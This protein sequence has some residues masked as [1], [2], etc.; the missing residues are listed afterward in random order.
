MKRLLL[1]GGGQV[2]ALVLRALARRRLTGVDVVLVTPSNQLRYSGMLPGWVAGHYA[3]RELTVEL[4]QLARA[5]GARLIPAQLRKLDLANRIAF[6]DT[7]E[8]IDFDLLS[9]ATGAV[10]DMDAIT[11][12]RQHALP[13]RPFEHFIGD[14]ES[15]VRNAQIVPE[16]FRLTVVGAG[17]AGVEIALAAAY[18]ARAMRSPMHVRVLTGGM[19]LLPGHGNRARSL[20]HAVLAG[21]HVQ[22]IDAVAQ[23]VESDA[24]ITRDD[25]RLAT[26]ATLVATG[27][28]APAWL[29]DTRLA[30]DDRGFIAVN[31]HLQSISHSFVFAAGDVATLTETPRPKSGVYAVRAAKPLALNLTA[32]LSGKPL[33]VFTP[34]RRALYL[35]STG[36]K[37]A[38]A[39]WGRTGFAGHWVWR[40]KNR[41]DRDYIAN[42][43]RP[44]T[45]EP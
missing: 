8:A 25:G 13:L 15:T 3:L 31:S 29:R 34:Q 4:A 7:E 37:H 11:G 43:R 30:L 45:D 16:G 27:A 18:S 10:V 23:R 32:A 35:L 22:I 40:W 38:I 28:N 6:T 17:A 19:P 24:I 26:D 41:I 36:P 20:M 1:A 9:I 14:W 39:S 21:S 42:L 5:A 2:H 44:T 12:A 33:A